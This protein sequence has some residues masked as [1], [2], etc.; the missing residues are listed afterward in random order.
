MA[1]VPALQFTN[2]QWLSL[3]LAAPVVAYGAWPFHKAAWTNLRHG[4]ATMDTLV[5]LGTLAALGW[6]LWALFFGH[7]GMPRHDRTR[8][9]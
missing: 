2:W 5:S 9:S 6:S 4:A 1:M 3:T 7:A 8:S